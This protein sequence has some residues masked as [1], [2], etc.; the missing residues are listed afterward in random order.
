MKTLL[1]FITLPLSLPID[2][3]WDFI[4]CAVIG[5]IAFRLAYSFA[6]EN[7]SSGAG[8][9]ALH[10]LVRLPLYLIIWIFACL[11]ILSVKFIIANWVWAVLAGIVL[12]IVGTVIRIYFTIYILYALLNKATNCKQS[13]NV[14][15]NN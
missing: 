4:I 13:G 9:F 10:W 11:I 2:P 8:R 5:E 12:S 3:I 6:G 7:A 15:K 1:D 14:P